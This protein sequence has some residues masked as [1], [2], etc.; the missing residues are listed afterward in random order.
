MKYL[1]LVAI[2]VLVVGLF[3]WPQMPVES[4]ELFYKA[5]QF[6]RR[7]SSVFVPKAADNMELDAFVQQTKLFA[8]AGDRQNLDRMGGTIDISG[9]TAIVGSFGDNGQSGAGY[10]FVRNGLAWTLQQKLVAPDGASQDNCGAVAIEGNTAVLGCSASDPGGVGSQGALYV[11]VRSGSVWTLQQK[12]THAEGIS[13][14]FLGGRVAISG[15]TIVATATGDDVNNVSGV[16]SAYVFVRNGMTWT[17]QARLNGSTVFFADSLGTD[18]D[19]SGDTVI[20]SAEFS[21]IGA[22]NA[23]VAFVFL[24]TGTTWVQQAR[25]ASTDPAA[26]DFFGSGVGISGD[27]IV[28]G[29]RQDAANN[30]GAGHV[31]VRSGGTWTHQQKLIASDGATNDSLGSAA[32]EGNNIIL[33]TSADFVQTIN[34]YAYHFTR[35]G[36]TWTQAQKLVADDGASGDSFGRSVAIGEGSIAIGAPEDDAGSVN[37]AGSAYVFAESAANISGRVTTPGGQSLRNAIVILTDSQGVRRT[38]TTGS[39]GLYIFINIPTG[40]G[41]TIS[42][43]S[44]RYRFVPRV[45]N[46]NS[47]LE[48]IDFAGLE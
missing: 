46:V 11:F 22:N 21:D 33:G 20:V 47:N 13:A 7:D 23:G 14:D 18:I 29:E 1:A 16:G 24:R 12:L 34:G 45:L 2:P 48:D 31:F 6:S 44:R 5:G 37:A 27:T 3:V 9:D 40:P 8:D 28:V 32:I 15:E 17:E 43:A 41:Y 36:I 30:Q 42:V 39:F 26:S 35:T 4:A 10:V 38:A 25:L 19:I